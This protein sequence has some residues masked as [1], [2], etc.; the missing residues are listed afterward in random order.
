MDKYDFLK[1]LENDAEFRNDVKRLLF[2]EEDAKP[3]DDGNNEVLP[4][5][6]DLDAEN[7]K[8]ENALAYVDLNTLRKL[9]IVLP[10]LSE[11]M[12]ELFGNNTY[13]TQPDKVRDDLREQL[14]RCFE[15]LEKYPEGVMFS[16]D[17]GVHTYF[18]SIN[19]AFYTEAGYSVDLNTH[20]A[21]P[22][23]NIKFSPIESLEF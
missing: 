8:I 18:Y 15:M 13:L 6:R 12:K 2:N 9:V 11:E 19:G 22:F 14:K 23:V 17:D 16:R 3:K 4:F 21:E 5:E 10:E 20:K 1:A 7:K